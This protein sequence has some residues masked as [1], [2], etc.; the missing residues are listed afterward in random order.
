[1]AGISSKAAGKLENRF[2]YNGKELQSKEFSDGSGLE[3]YD[4]GARMQDPQLGVWHNPDPLS[5][6]SRRWSPYAYAADN[7]IKY[8]DVDGMYFDDHYVKDGKKVAVVRTNDKYDRTIEIKKGDIKVTTDSKGADWM[9][10]SQGFESTLREVRTK[11][12]EVT[13]SAKSDASNKEPDGTPNSK[14][15]SA[16][17][18]GAGLGES[19]A[20]AGKNAAKNAFR[21]SEVGSEVAQQLK[22]VTQQ[23]GALAT[24]LKAAGKV[25]GVVSAYNSWSEAIEKGGA[26]RYAKAGVE[27]ALI[28]V[29]TN[30]IVG[31]VI[32][33]SDLTG[34]TDSLFKW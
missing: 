3:L 11:S 16:V 31:T 1:M 23:A 33:L 27:T 12:G 17:G 10:V 25:A 20:D 21:N 26:G 6:K 34:V 7:P 13:Y 2:K 28:F 14:T 32:A 15:A 19:M 18:V 4:Y 30:P 8:I 5:E 24:T 29:K 9:S 22:G